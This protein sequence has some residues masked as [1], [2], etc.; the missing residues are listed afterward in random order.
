MDLS[1]LGIY[2]VA[3]VEVAPT[4]TLH[5]NLRRGGVRCKGDLI[6]VTQT[7]DPVNIV[8][9]VGICRVA[10]EQHKVYLVICDPC[11]YLLSAAL[12][13]VKIQCHGKSRS[14]G[15]ELARGVRCAHGMLRKNEFKNVLHDYECLGLNVIG[16]D[17]SAKF[18][19]E[20]AGVTDPERKR[21]IIGK[22]FID[23]FDAC[24]LYTLTLPTILRV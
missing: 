14:L 17:A 1:P 15:H 8:K 19:G 5:Q 3:P 10:E 24:L 9:A 22:G 12:I 11:A 18:F 7:L 23:V 6:L 2:D 21:K 16:V 20:L 4:Q 13:G